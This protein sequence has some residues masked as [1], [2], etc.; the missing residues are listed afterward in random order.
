[1]SWH[2]GQ[3][4]VTIA[5]LECEGDSSKT[6]EFK[7]QNNLKARRS[8]AKQKSAA[9]ADLIMSRAWYSVTRVKFTG[10]NTT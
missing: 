9:P 8:V 5:Q 10:W 4:Q 6:D 7:L 1:M 3:Y 2:G